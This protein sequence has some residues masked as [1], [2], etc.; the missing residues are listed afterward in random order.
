MILYKQFLFLFLFRRIPQIEM[1][2]CFRP[3]D[4]IL[5]RVVS[6]GDAR[7]YELSTSAP[8]LGVVTARCEEGHHMV[9]ASWTS[10]KCKCRTEN[11]KVA[12]VVPENT[13]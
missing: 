6:L 8:E 12:K 2:E 11:R 9:P 5:A 1:Y 10:M 4:I 13:R 7:S 3:D